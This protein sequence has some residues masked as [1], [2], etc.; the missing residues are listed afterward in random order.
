M[1]KHWVL[2][3]NNWHANCVF[4]CSDCGRQ[5]RLYFHDGKY[6]IDD[7]GNVTVKKKPHTTAECVAHRASSK[8]SYRVERKIRSLDTKQFEFIK[9]LAAFIIDKSNG[10]VTSGGHAKIEGTGDFLGR[11]LAMVDNAGGLSGGGWVVAEVKF[12]RGY[13]LVFNQSE[14]ELLDT[15]DKLIAVGEVMAA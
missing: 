3:Q 5:I 1:K 14:K 4:E 8:E 6:D 11:I 7:D 13:V 15:I 10:F 9:G 2:V 12:K